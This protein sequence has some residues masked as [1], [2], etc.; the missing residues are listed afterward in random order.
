MDSQPQFLLCIAVA[1]RGT[2]RVHGIEF[3]REWRPVQLGGEALDIGAPVPVLDDATAAQIE[4]DEKIGALATR[5]A[6]AEEVAAYQQQLVDAKGKDPDAVIADLK[7]KNAELEAR[8][9]KLELASSTPK[10]GDGGKADKGDQAKGDG[11]KA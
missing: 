11:G 9:M 10:K 1:P 3:S 7:A 6:T 5:P 4:Y 2:W 8:M